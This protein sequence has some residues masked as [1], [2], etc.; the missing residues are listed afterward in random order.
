MILDHIAVNV[1]NIADGVE[2]YCDNL[3]DVCIL[4]QDETWAMLE[5]GGAKLA[6]TISNQHRPHVAFRVESPPQGFKTHR[7]GSKFVYLS[8][9]YGNVIEMICYS[10]DK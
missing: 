1:E 4:Y 10:E 3:L 7:D 8:D 2:W 9:P 6:L 5:V